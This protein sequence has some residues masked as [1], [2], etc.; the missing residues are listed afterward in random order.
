MMINDDHY[1][2]FH[3]GSKPMSYAD[4]VIQI[5]DRLGVAWQ[6]KLILK[7]GQASPLSQ[8]LNTDKLKRVFK[9]VAK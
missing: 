6:G 9:L 3:I 5:C 7:E 2:I 1:G 8:E 4:R